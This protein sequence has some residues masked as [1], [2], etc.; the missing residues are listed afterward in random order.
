MSESAASFELYIQRAH[1]REK[2]VS[3][4]DTGLNTL[5]GGRI[6]K[7]SQYIDQDD[8]FAVTYGD[9]LSNIPVDKL[10]E[11]HKSHGKHA[12]VSAS[13]MPGRFGALEISKN[14]VR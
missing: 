1:T 10:V 14:E 2:K 7:V 8:Y 12:T 4:I 9:G 13:F 11:F 3:C 6:K 5:T